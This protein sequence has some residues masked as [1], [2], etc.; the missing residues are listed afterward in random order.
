M[1]TFRE[2]HHE[3]E[4]DERLWDSLDG[5]LDAAQQAVM[6]RHLLH[7][8][9][10]RMR[11][12]EF[13]SLDRRLRQAT[14]PLTLDADFDRRVL[15]QLTVDRADRATARRR[16]AREIEAAQAT[17]AR[18]WRHALLRVVPGMLAGVVTTTFLAQWLGNQATLSK[19]LPATAGQPV[20][21]ALL[22]AGLGAAV[23][24]WLTMAVDN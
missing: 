11:L 14:G 23:A 13:R 2:L 16:I 6:E 12:V 20:L 4:W 8:V 21:I 5:A 3:L 17:L 15:A 22:G 19:W 18:S 24:G 7:C 9:D 1:T 10:C